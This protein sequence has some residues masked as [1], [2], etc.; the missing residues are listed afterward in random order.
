MTNVT[1]PKFWAD[2]LADKAIPSNREWN[3]RLNEGIYS[4]DTQIY[5]NKMHIYLI[6]GRHVSHEK[7]IYIM[8]PFLKWRVNRAKKNLIIKE[9]GRKAMLKKYSNQ[10]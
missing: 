3:Q 7:T 6:N 2:G 1:P 8:L 4:F 5:G 10:S 9:R